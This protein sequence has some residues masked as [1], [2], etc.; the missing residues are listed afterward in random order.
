MENASETVDIHWM[1]RAMELAERGRGATRPN[2]MVGAVL[3]ADG[4]VVGEGYHQRA[5]EAHA[6][7]HALGAAGEAAR[8]A[9][10]YVTL[11]PCC[12]HG[13]T[14]P[15]T[16]ALIEAGVARVVA[17]AIDPNPKVAGQGLERLQAAGIEVSRSVLAD[18]CWEMNVVFNHWVTTGRPL[19]VL[20][21]AT[22]LDGRIAA[23]G[24]ASQWITGEDARREVHAMRAHLEGVMV[25]SGTALADD[26]RLTAREVETPGGQPTRILVDGS[27]RVP[28]SAQLFSDEGEVIVATASG[29]EQAIAARR[30]AGATVLSL[31]GDEGRVDLAALLDALGG[32]E[33]EP[34]TGLLVEG[35]GGLAG[36]LLEADL[37]DRLHLFVAPTFMG[38][39]GISAVG[40]LGVTHPDEAPRFDVLRLN[41]LGDDIEIVLSRRP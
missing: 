19:V 30:A 34:I 9:T 24:G 8:G 36:A 17:G 38:G 13:R 10:A 29:D 32:H 1:A 6:E 27:L 21:L 41:T 37:V 31:E 20:K 2:P 5:G 15:C 40:S 7:I 39:D 28:T 16:E 3:V 12:Y 35:G 23:A 22:T 26:P 11:E 14:G 33:P 18:A 25:G 4:E